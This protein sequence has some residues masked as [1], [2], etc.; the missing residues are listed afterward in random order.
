[1]RLR[2]G[3]KIS[4]IG[5]LILIVSFAL[6]VIIVTSLANRGLS[7]QT[8]ENLV[9]LAQAM[10]D[11]TEARFQGDMRVSSL[12]AADGEVVT[13]VETANSGDRSNPVFSALS[14]KLAALKKMPEFSSSYDAILVV[15]RSGVIVAASI[16]SV[17]GLDVKEREYFISGMAGKTGVGQMMVSKTGVL[18]AGV[19]APILDKKGTVIGVSVVSLL[20]ESIM[21]EMAKFKLGK[22]GF[23]AAIDR[24]GLMILHPNKDM[25]LKFNMAEDPE[26]KGVAANAL[27]GKTEFERYTFKGARKATAY[28]TV[29]S[30]GWVI[31]PAMP[32]SE[33][34]AT[35]NDLRNTIIVMAIL[36]ILVS[37]VIFF[38]LAQSISKPINRAAEKAKMIANGDLEHGIAQ[39]F[40]DRGDEIGDLAAAFKLQRDTL[41][42]IVGEISQAVS[43]VAQGSEQLSMTAQQM[44]QGATEQAASV[45]EITS[46]VEQMTANIKQNAENA[47]MTEKIAL[48]SAANAEEGG[49]AVTRTVEAMKLIASKTGI[50]EEIARSTNMLALNASIEAARAGEYGKGFA[51]VASEV[52]KLAERSQKEAGEIS[53]L[54]AES[55]EIAEKAG[56]TILAIIPDIKKT[57]E[58]VQEISA[59][60]G[61][62][63]SGAAQINQAILQLDQVVQQNASA[64][65]ESASMSEELAGQA[66]QLGETISFFKLGNDGKLDPAVSK[67]VTKPA[68][69]ATKS[70]APSSVARKSAASLPAAGKKPAGAKPAGIVIALDD[71]GAQGTGRDAVDKEF[72]EY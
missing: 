7:A 30:T 40:L 6:L 51:V 2:I 15:D 55:V 37:M 62:Q 12:L 18:T 53:K 16:P 68:A 29:P 9:N 61:E 8:S 20:T 3:G 52:G 24:K 69:T 17:V 35:A 57:A 5:S 33:F 31:M 43:N 50:I 42:Q 54:S 66:E 32:E 36:A 28:C 10:A 49:M 71:D 58:L 65:E 4:L 47:Q 13:A 60:S 70:G 46:S 44:S 34:L 11:Y 39:V 59:A 26:C 56:A 23:F 25:V 19:F 22:T 27:S 63:N 38:L 64:S 67:S 14:G 1:M 21:N 72:K 45:E 41:H 48:K